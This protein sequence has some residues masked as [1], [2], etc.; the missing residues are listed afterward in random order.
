MVKAV[1]L[2]SRGIDPVEAMGVGA[3]ELERLGGDGAKAIGEFWKKYYAEKTSGD[4][5][6]W[7]V[8]RN[9]KQHNSFYELEEKEFFS[10]AV[11]VFTNVQDG[12]AVVKSLFARRGWKSHNTWPREVI[13]IT[14]LPA[15]AGRSRRGWRLAK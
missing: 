6:E 8:K 3:K 14:H 10:K 13:S 7:G 15:L 2:L 9:A 4:D 12:R 1:N 5:P 11:S